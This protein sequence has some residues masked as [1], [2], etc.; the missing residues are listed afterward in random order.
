MAVEELASNASG[1]GVCNPLAVVSGTFAPII[2]FSIETD[3]ASPGFRI[4]TILG[5]V[6]SQR[7]SADSGTIGVRS[8]KDASISGTTLPMTYAL[9]E[10][11]S[12]ISL[13]FR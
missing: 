3:P 4:A 8:S 13:S 9:L 5:P 6:T 2:T 11:V 7:Y 1:G 12:S 10:A